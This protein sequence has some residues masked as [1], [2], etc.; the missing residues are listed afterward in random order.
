MTEQDYETI[1]K[2]RWLQVNELAIKYPNDQ[3]FGAQVRE[4]INKWTMEFKNLVANEE[5][6]MDYDQLGHN[7]QEWVIDYIDICFS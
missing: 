2:L 1:T 5:F 3:E 7:E 4:L 6:G